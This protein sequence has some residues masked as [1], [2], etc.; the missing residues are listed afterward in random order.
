MVTL[1]LKRIYIHQELT[2]VY[3][4]TPFLDNNPILYPLKTPENYDFLVFLGG[5]EWEHLPEIEYCQL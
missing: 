4:I 1:Q 5:I 3:G 2:G